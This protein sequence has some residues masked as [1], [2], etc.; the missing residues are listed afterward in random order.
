MGLWIY[1]SVQCIVEK[2]AGRIWMRFGMVS[3]MASQGMRQVV[4]FGDR[5]TEVVILG[6][7]A[8]RPIV[9]NAYRCE[10]A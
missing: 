3:R 9:T 1:E 4:G 8:A 2:T 6:A 10:S 7:N 5:S